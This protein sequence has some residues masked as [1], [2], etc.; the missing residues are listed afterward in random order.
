M[1]TR[2]HIIAGILL[3][4]SLY[5]SLLATDNKELLD[6][7]LSIKTDK[8]AF[9]PIEPIIIEYEAKNDGNKEAL[10]HSM[11]DTSYGFVFF[12]H[13]PKGSLDWKEYS[14]SHWGIEKTTL[15]QYYFKPGESISGTVRLYGSEINDFYKENLF[16]IKMR[17]GNLYFKNYVESSIIEFKVISP[18][19]ENLK[20]WN[21]IKEPFDFSAFLAG[22]WHKVE[23]NLIIE[24][25]RSVSA[26]YPDSDYAKLTSATLVEYDKY[27]KR[28]EEFRKKM[29][30][31]EEEDRFYTKEEKEKIGERIEELLCKTLQEGWNNSDWDKFVSIARPGSNDRTRFRDQKNKY[32]GGITDFRTKYGEIKGIKIS[33]MEF[34]KNKAFASIIISYSEFGNYESDVVLSPDEKGMWWV[35]SIDIGLNEKRQ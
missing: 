35:D 27:R 21:E 7:K 30:K 4:S 15:E 31:A 9:L 25:Y 20:F 33:D 17:I 1:S 10:F 14:D 6:L 22:K 11:F 28:E 8:E 26:K 5:S 29:E 2:Q 34:Q 23:S 19:G 18:K 13:R 12:Y 3:A 32:V 24:E 16:E